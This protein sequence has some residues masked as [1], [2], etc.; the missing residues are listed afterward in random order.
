[1]SCQNIFGAC[2][3]NYSDY[4]LQLYKEKTKPTHLRVGFCFRVLSF[5]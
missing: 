1:M 2:A 4:E 3:A 5:I